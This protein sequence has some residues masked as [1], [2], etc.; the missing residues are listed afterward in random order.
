M[1]CFFSYNFLLFLMFEALFY[2]LSFDIWQTSWNQQIKQ[3]LSV[4]SQWE[5]RVIQEP[6]TVVDKNV[7]NILSM[8]I[9]RY[10]HPPCHVSWNLNPTPP[11][12]TEGVVFVVLLFC[13]LQLSKLLW[14]DLLFPCNTKTITIIN[15]YAPHFFLTSH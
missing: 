13:G 9:V 14:N 2:Y 10:P 8:S 5:N 1:Q 15:T 7:T 4:I 11:Q 6:K 3:K 12:I